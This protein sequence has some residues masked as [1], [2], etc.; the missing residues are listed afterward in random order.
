MTLLTEWLVSN[1]ILASV[2]AV[3]AWLVSYRWPHKPAFVHACWLVVILKLLTPPV[4]FISL[5]NANTSS[6]LQET[7]EGILTERADSTAPLNRSSEQ[8]AETFDFDDMAKAHLPPDQVLNLPSPV[9]EPTSEITK[10]VNAAVTPADSGGTT[11]RKTLHAIW[12]LWCTYFLWFFP[13]VTMTGAIYLAVLTS[14]RVL[15]FERSLAYTKAASHSIQQ[16]VEKLAR[17]MQI[18]HCPRV[19]VTLGRVGP[20]LWHRRKFALIVMP[21]GLLDTLSSA[22]L[23]TV[24]AHELAHYRRGDCR[25]R[26][27]EVLATIF[28]WWL[29]TAW[30]ASRQLRQAEESCCDATVVATLP[31]AVNL[32]AR[33]L[34]RSLSFITETGTC[35]P[36]LSIGLGPVSSLQRRLT[37]L[38]MQVKSRLGLH[39]W[40]LILAAASLLPMGLSWVQAQDE[41]SAK[42]TLHPKPNVISEQLAQKE[43]EKVE[44]NSAVQGIPPEI[45][46]SEP[47][48]YLVY[49]SFQNPPSMQERM[50]AMQQERQI[51]AEFAVR[52][53][54]L[55]VRAKEARLRQ[56]DR[57]RERLKKQIEKSKQRLLAGALTQEEFDQFERQLAISDDEK[58]LAMIELDRSQLHLE[59]MKTQYI[60]AMRPLRFPDNASSPPAVPF[61]AQGG[62][63]PGARGQQ[64][65]VPGQPSPVVPPAPPVAPSRPQVP[66]GTPPPVPTPGQSGPGGSG[67]EGVSGSSTGDAEMATRGFG[68]GSN[69]IPKPPAR[70]DP[71]D[72]RIQQLER[73]LRELRELLNK[74]KQGDKKGLEQI[75]N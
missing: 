55:E 50:Q 48:N 53:A 72:V 20:L 17:Q 69:V 73:E 8:P 18:K 12:N 49:N 33:A 7:A 40:L 42:P 10:G 19:V 37:M 58:E 62:F 15:R 57:T 1:A 6:A 27:L 75:P 51:A 28:Y 2:L 5:S 39:G 30:L 64:G 67:S 47:G 38:P 24:L 31:D 9:L 34:V 71:R 26:Y 65:F 4:Y 22:E 59:K 14:I 13:L 66:A 3:L 44:S 60:N 23:E 41:P 25:W 45:S 36:T 11:W 43:T 46:T 74:L 52:E 56:I 21:Q 68:T 61:P 29:P 35:S 16:S 63:V 32:Y 70:P 54:E